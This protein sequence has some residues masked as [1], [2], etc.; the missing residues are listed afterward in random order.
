M[1]FTGGNQM[2]LA[3]AIR[4]TR[5]GDAV[6]AAYERGVIVAGTSAG[7]SV[8]SE[9]M[10]GY[11]AS[12]A[13]PKL[14]DGL[15]GAGPRPASGVIVDQHFAQ[16]ERFGRL[17]TMVASSPDLLGIGLDEDTAILVT[18][19]TDLEVVGRGSVFCVDMR[20]ALSDAARRGDRPTD[21]LRRRRPLP[22]ARGA[23]RPVLAHPRVLP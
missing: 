2:K 16:R 3:A 19:E 13:H 22:P 21:D 9:H 10:V 11:G 5:F 15:R 14:P 18:D 4:G 7:A 6:V 12:G 23:L 1:F 8:V 17:M 20:T